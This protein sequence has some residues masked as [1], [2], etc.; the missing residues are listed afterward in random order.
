MTERGGEVS[1]PRPQ[2]AA[3]EVHR[4]DLRGVYL[5]SGDGDETATV[6]DLRLSLDEDGVRVARPDG[7]EV[8]GTPWDGVLELAAAGH[9]SLPDGRRGLELTVRSTSGA[10]HRFV[11]PS[12]DPGVLEERIGTLA[13]RHGVAPA[14]A[15]RPAPALL[16]GAV[17]L[18]T[19]AVVAVLL[20]A[21]GHVIHL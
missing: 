2:H 10:P 1:R 6:P 15:D 16:V 12:D 19:A 9:A 20:L 18:A 17:L 4:F 21:A 13:A 14:S 5:L 3:G 8:W 11:A 7:S